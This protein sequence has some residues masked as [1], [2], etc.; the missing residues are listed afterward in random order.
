M[1][2][3]ILIGFV[4]RNDEDVKLGDID[5]KLLSEDSIVCPQE[6]YTEKCC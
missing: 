6:K 5:N 4:M 3:I 2:D 1:L